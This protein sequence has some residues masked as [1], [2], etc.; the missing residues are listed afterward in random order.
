MVLLHSSKLNAN[1]AGRGGGGLICSKLTFSLGM[2]LQALK[3]L[4]KYLFL[5]D[6]Y[7][8]SNVYAQAEMLNGLLKPIRIHKMININYS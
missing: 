3:V 7:L 8:L 4:F 5:K 1:Q 6:K 2:H